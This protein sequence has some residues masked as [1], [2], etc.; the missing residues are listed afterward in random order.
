[1]APAASAVAGVA[2]TAAAAAF[3]RGQV[4]TD[5]AGGIVVDGN[6]KVRSYM[7][8][9]ASVDGVNTVGV[10]APNAHSQ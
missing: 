4:E 7:L 3:C 6:F 10:V 1:M 5:K 8:L 9:H 2:L